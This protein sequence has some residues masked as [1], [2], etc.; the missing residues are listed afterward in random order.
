[1]S[2]PS[3]AAGL[4]AL[5]LRRGMPGEL[6]TK[7]YSVMLGYWGDDDKTAQAID[8][9]GWMHTGDLVIMDE[10]GYGN[11]VG[12]LKDMVIRGGEN[13]YPREIEEYLYRHRSEERRVGQG[14]VSTC[15]S[16]W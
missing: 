10:R 1:M 15:R 4:L 16:R 13:I 3:L 8:A 5:G 11:V 14:C 6:C 2:G 9:E 7:G 12:R